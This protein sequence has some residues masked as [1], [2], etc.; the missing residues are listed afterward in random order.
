MFYFSKQIRSLSLSLGTSFKP[1]QVGRE[2]LFS[3][4]TDVESKARGFDELG[5]GVPAV[6][7]V[8][9]TRTPDSQ[10]LVQSHLPTPCFYLCMM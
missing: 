8:R 6:S 5:W 1:C 10:L 9:N 4:F 3:H 2:S 7:G